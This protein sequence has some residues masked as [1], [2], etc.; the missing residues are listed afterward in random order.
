MTKSPDEN[1]Y[2][3]CCKDLFQYKVNIEPFEMKIFSFVHNVSQRKELINVS[4]RQNHEQDGRHRF[5]NRFPRQFPTSVE[6]EHVWESLTKYPREGITEMQL[7]G[8]FPQPRVW[9]YNASPLIEWWYPHTSKITLLLPNYT[10]FACSKPRAI[11]SIASESV[12]R[13]ACL[14]KIFF[15]FPWSLHLSHIILFSKNEI[16]P[17][18]SIFLCIVSCLLNALLLC[19]IHFTVWLCL[20]VTQ[21]LISITN[22]LNISVRLISILKQTAYSF[23]T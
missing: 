13:Q 2:A 21:F 3:N 16:F 19:R 20:S 7:C 9:I 8:T 23:K 18:S 4:Y 10:C 11:F 17:V 12:S 1:C 5:E 15:F 6:K 22:N 14:L